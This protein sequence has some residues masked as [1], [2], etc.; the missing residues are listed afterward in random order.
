MFPALPLPACRLEF[1]GH[2]SYNGETVTALVLKSSPR[3]WN[4]GSTSDT[5]WPQ[6][7]LCSFLSPSPQPLRMAL[8]L[9]FSWGM[10]FHVEIISGGGCKQ[11]P[12]FALEGPCLFLSSNPQGQ[13]DQCDPGVLTPFLLLLLADRF[14]NHHSSLTCFTSPLPSTGPFPLALTQVECPH[15]LKKKKAKRPSLPDATWYPGDWTGS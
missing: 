3:S 10:G 2:S 13:P 11:G 5:A 15:V 12:S 6:G 9:F 1:P 8:G 7:S 4:P 14:S